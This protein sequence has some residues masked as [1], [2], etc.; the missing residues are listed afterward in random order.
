MLSL[1]CGFMTETL[2]VDTGIFYYV[3]QTKKIKLKNA[4]YK[5]GMKKSGQVKSQNW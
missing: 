4:L 5:R 3:K 2:F 1:V